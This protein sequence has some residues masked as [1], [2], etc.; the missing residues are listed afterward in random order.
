MRWRMSWFSYLWALGAVALA[1]LATSAVNHWIAPAL[2]LLFF[3]AVV[4][5]AM[6]WGY[7]PALFAT[8]ASTLCLAYFFVPPAYSFNIGVDDFTR[9]TAFVV[10]A[11][12]TA[13]V[14]LARRRAEAA[15]RN[16]LQ[17]LQSVNNALRKVSEWPVLVGPDT[18]ELTR[19][20]LEYAAE[21]AGATETIAI[22]EAEE[23]PW[24]Y[25][26]APSRI[27]VITRHKPTELAAL[28]SKVLAGSRPANSVAN[29]HP[30]PAL[31]L[32]FTGRGVQAV[33]FKTKHLNGRVF[34]TGIGDVTERI[35][36]AV[37]LVAREV[38]SSLDQIYL[39]EQMRGL[40]ADEERIRLAR[41]LHDGVLQSLTGIRLQLQAIAAET[42][43]HLSL[44][45]R[46]VA[47][48]RALALEQ[49]ELRL[50]I[51]DI[52]PEK[53]AKSE[54]GDLALALEEMRHR[55]GV[56]WKTPISIRVM[57]PTTS[58]PQTTY[59]TLKLMIHEAVINALKHAHPSRV[60]VAVQAED[61]G[62]LRI[63][64]T[65]DGKG[66]PFTGRLEHDALVRSDAGPLSLRDR[67]VALGGRM[68]V[69]SGPSGACVEIL[70]PMEA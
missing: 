6:Y 14:S 34:F 15:L 55:L 23:E 65:N 17:D 30:N 26:A 47:I 20:M 61:A 62:Q 10:V 66:F 5:P 8:V 67:V 21:S 11:V 31:S 53:Q 35:V 29:D 19:Q 28:V 37:E 13:S 69:E 56:E 64:V 45:D 52:R 39:T 33:P 7:G 12:A 36:P 63:L 54:V 60:S 42:A 50:F 41:D 43:G 40:A 38:G 25:L 49:R 1:A 68:A 58:V 51:D 22:W 70:L 59:R 44:N 16:S 48:E 32:D 9:L 18:L 57:P 2:S 46:L 24:L 3:P 27:D 4:I